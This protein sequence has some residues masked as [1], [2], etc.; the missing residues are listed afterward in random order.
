M[1]IVILNR[2]DVRIN[3]NLWYTDKKHQATMKNRIIFHGSL[4]LKL[5]KEKY[6]SLIYTDQ[7]S[8]IIT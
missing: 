6:V 1:N 3:K 8:G 7:I 5:K 4:M 2:D